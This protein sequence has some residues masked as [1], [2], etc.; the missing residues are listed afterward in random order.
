MHHTAART[1]CNT[2]CLHRSNPGSWLQA[3]TAR[4][5]HLT[6]NRRLCTRQMSVAASALQDILAIGFLTSA[7]AGLLYSAVPLLTGQSKEKN[8][9]RLD[10]YKD[11]DADPDD[12][13]WGVM[14]VVSFIPL[15]NW[16]VGIN[17]LL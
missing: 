16:T 15:V 5:Q 3:H 17:S 14:S 11:K 10:T 1:F 7:S 4:R 8:Q 12:V 13:K 6:A 2:D 9:S